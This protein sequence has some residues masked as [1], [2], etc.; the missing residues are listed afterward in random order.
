MLLL[1][2][3]G[4]AIAGPLTAGVA[5]AKITPAAP[6]Q[7][8][9]GYDS[10]RRAET[11]HDDV[12]CR[13]VALGDGQ[14]TVVLAVCDLLGFMYPD[15][16]EMRSS[17]EGVPADH[18]V[19]AC[20]HVHSA[21][22]VIGLWGPSPAQ[23][24]VDPAYLAFV[25][26][27]VTRCLNDA[28]RAMAPA[29]IGF[30][31]GISGPH[32]SINSN[33]PEV[34]D[35]AVDVMVV[36][37]ANG[38][39]LATLVNWACHP[40]VLNTPSRAVTSDLSHYLREELEGRV[41]GTALFFNGALGGMVTA[42]CTAQT[43]AEAERI[44]RS[45]G[46]TAAELVAQAPM[47]AD[48]KI[49]VASKQIEVPLANPAFGL[50]FQ[51]GV[52]RRPEKSLERLRTEVAAFSIGPA[53]FATCPGEALPA[54]GLTAK[55]MMPG[56][57][58]FFFAVAQDELGYILPPEYFPLELYDYEVSMSVGPQVAPTVLA[59]LAELLPQVPPA[60]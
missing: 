27:Q 23:S 2:A 14:Q 39:L 9:A 19:L 13:A 20:T 18:V 5:T 6:G 12:W 3:T 35:K 37:G 57:P 31:S 10:N 50:A 24:G 7:F 22:D 1:A 21:P 48:L 49:S 42:D 15:A 51:A 25:K 16:L 32:T 29:Q 52:I 55:G 46:A 59:A 38:E 36:R 56:R 41:G 11:V 60:R 30:A 54:V 58:T 47:A 43:F 4:A 17:V 26:A 28:V 34:N 44:G 40:E 8:L 45:V 33:A 53:Q